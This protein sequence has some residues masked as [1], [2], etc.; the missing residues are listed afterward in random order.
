MI[1]KPKPEEVIT[2]LSILGRVLLTPDIFDILS[3]TKPGAGGEIQLTDA[4]R[5]LARSKGMTAV[6]FEGTRY[7]MGS[8][9]GFLFANVETALKDPE[10][11]PEFKTY[12]KE[13]AKKL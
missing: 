11:G 7:D 8:K 12:I 13:L 9:L 2:R 3:S 5:D 1:E 10:L 6:D 4:M